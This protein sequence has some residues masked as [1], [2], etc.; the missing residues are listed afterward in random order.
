MILT[1]LRVLPLAAV[2]AATV[3]L[4]A[5]STSGSYEE[6]EERPAEELYSEARQAMEEG[7]YVEATRLFEEVERQHPY[8]KWATEAQLMAALSSYE[9][10]RYDEAVLALDRFIELHPGNDRIDYA[11]YLKA[12]TY[13][14]Q[15]SDV[16]RDQEMTENALD[17]F[18]TLIRRFPSSK[19]A[20][21]AQLKRDLTE[22]H[23]AG[24]EMEIGRYYLTRGHIN[25]AINR[26]QTVVRDYQT[27]THVPEALHRLVEAYLTLGL[28]DEATKA[29]AVLGYNYPGSQWYQDS[30]QLLDDAQRQQILEDRSWIYKTVDSLFARE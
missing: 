1:K 18:D 23:L 6:G 26:F 25:A 4:A 14:E 30:Y 28:R 24:K 21:D 20:R 19:Y 22:D 9:D 3:S 16:R 8:S 17:A 2:L 15:I 7:E 11:Y 10:Q 5:C 29:A 12:L 27:T 13:Y